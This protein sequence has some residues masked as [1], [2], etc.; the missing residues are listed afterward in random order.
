MT[1]VQ[2]C[3]LPI[4]SRDRGDDDWGTGT[5]V[6]VVK[7]ALT[8]LTGTLGN[9]RL[10]WFVI[11]D[12]PRV[13]REIVVRDPARGGLKPAPR[14]GDVAIFRDLAGQV[15]HSAVVRG[16]ASDG[17]VILES[18]WGWAGRFLHTPAGQCYGSDCTFYRTERPAGLAS[19]PAVVACHA[20]EEARPSPR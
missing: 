19:G 4:C 20:V 17:L 12:D 11:P 18:K 15:T 3:A 7:R 6:R 14:P 13:S 8:Q 5:V 9:N 2:T 10:Q 1:G 16:L